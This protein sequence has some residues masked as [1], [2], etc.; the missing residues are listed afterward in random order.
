MCRCMVPLFHSAALLQGEKE[1]CGMLRGAEICIFYAIN[2]PFLLPRPSS[3]REILSR[4]QMF[5]GTLP[6]LCFFQR[7]HT[8]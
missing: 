3:P 2:A 8:H 1:A 5:S 7:N 6:S 4:M